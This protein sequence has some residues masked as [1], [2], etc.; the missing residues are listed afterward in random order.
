LAFSLAADNNAL[1]NKAAELFQKEKAEIKNYKVNQEVTSKIKEPSGNAIEKRIQVGYFQRPEEYIFICKEIE[2]NG[3]KQILAKP[4][5]ERV[6]KLEVDWLSREG[7]NSHSFQ[8]LSSDSKTIKYLVS[9]TK[10]QSGYFRGQLWLDSQT[11]RIVKI[12]K[13][14][15]LKKR[16]MI[17][18]SLE[19]NFEKEFAFQ[20]P[21]RTILSA[22]YQANNQVTEV[23][24][25]ANF[26]DYKFNLD[27]A[28]EL[29]K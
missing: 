14:P 5:I 13:E 20:V 6:S 27:L 12:L 24:V 23:Q 8:T 1:L 17:K 4:L 15:I 9:P 2:M 21:T 18:Y 10:I 22:I 25:E 26:T 11:A 3:I 19:L 7:L 16:E 29:P 28:N